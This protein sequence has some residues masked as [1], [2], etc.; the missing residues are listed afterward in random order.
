MVPE[1]HNK[2]GKINVFYLPFVNCGI[3]SHLDG[4]WDGFC[5][6]FLVAASDHYVKND[7]PVN[8]VRLLDRVANRKRPKS[9]IFTPRTA[10][11][12]THLTL[13]ISNHVL[14]KNSL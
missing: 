2:D 14:A 3:S 5:C 6:A 4:F 7:K 1:I 12:F 11:I 8:F 10:T 13:K 9:P